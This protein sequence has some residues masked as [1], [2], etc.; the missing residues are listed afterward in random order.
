LLDRTLADSRLHNRI[1][2]VSTRPTDL[3]DTD[4]FVSVWDD[5]N[6]RSALGRI[7]CFD[8]SRDELTKYFQ[9]Q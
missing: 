6:K 7:A 3:S 5:L 8:A 4:R 2:I 1:V 9:P